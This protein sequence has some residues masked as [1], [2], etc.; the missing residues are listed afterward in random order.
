MAYGQQVKALFELSS[1]AEM[2]ENLWEIY[3]GFVNFEKQTGY[4]PRQANL[5]L[6]FRELMLFC[7]RIEAMK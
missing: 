5:F 6:T 7:S 1:P 2:V 4:N 3:S